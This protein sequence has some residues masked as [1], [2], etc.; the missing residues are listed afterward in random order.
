MFQEVQTF[1]TDAL[2]QVPLKCRKMLELQK[3]PEGNFSPQ[4]RKAGKIKPGL[5][6]N[7]A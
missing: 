6:E 3:I 4:Q 2:K 7:T 5:G 1:P